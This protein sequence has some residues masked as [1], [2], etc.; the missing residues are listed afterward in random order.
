MMNQIRRYFSVPLSG[1]L[2]AAIFG[3]IT[4]YTE[5][6]RDERPAIQFD[7]ISDS[8]VLDVRE[9][10]SDLQIIHAGADL[11]RSGK[12]L[13]VMVV[14]ISNIGGEDILKSFYD[15]EAPLGFSVANGELVSTEIQATSEAYLDD[16]VI[17]RVKDTSKVLFSPVILAPKSYFSVRVLIKHSE[18]TLPVLTPIGKIARVSS[19]SLVQ[20]PI[21]QVPGFWQ[22][23]FSPTYSWLPKFNG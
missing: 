11:R 4:I 2:L 16:R 18:S 1:F 12:S 7:V 14:R 10:V 8:S 15:G 19:I 17:L 13:R 20:A 3:G 6:V 22:Q 21:A 23:T 9:E 5:F